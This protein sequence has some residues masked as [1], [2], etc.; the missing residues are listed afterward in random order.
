L[1]GNNTQVGSQPHLLKKQ[2]SREDVLAVV[3]STVSGNV[4]PPPSRG[5]GHSG[6]L[7]AKLP[8]SEKSST[9]N[10]Q[11]PTQAPRERGRGGRGRGPLPTPVPRTEAVDR[12]FEGET[13]AGTFFNE[14]DLK[15]VPTADPSRARPNSTTQKKS[16]SIFDD[17]ELF[18]TVPA[19]PP[20]TKAPTSKKVESIFDDDELFVAPPKT[21]IKAPEPARA[22]AGATIFGDDDDLFGTGQKPTLKKTKSIFDDDDALFGVTKE[23]GKSNTSSLL[24]AVDSVLFE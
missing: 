15:Y 13:K 24:S 2:T 6:S 9:A 21:Q 5:R 22:K 18:V 7:Q 14:D 17:D 8:Q 16:A 3:Q 20:T 12:L 23:K 1:D 19:K 10:P 11:Q 4:R